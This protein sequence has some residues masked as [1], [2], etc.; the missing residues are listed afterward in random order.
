MAVRLLACLQQQPRQQEAAG[1]SRSESRQPRRVL[2]IIGLV[3]RVATVLITRLLRKMAVLGLAGTKFFA[4][5]APKMEASTAHPF[6]FRPLT[7][8][9][10]VRLPVGVTVPTHSQNCEKDSSLTPRT[11]GPGQ[12]WVQNGLEFGRSVFNLSVSGRPRG[13]EPVGRW[14]K[15]KTK[16]KGGPG[17]GA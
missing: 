12:K 1:G 5:G 3:A 13:S 14:E 16:N 8:E 15:Q 7:E 2:A 11:R 4:C 10:M 17:P 6:D 9:R